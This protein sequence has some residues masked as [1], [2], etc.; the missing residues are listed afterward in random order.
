MSTQLDIDQ[1]P[2][3]IDE[4]TI[5]IEGKDKGTLVNPSYETG[6]LG[7][8]LYYAFL[9]KYKNE[10]SHITTAETYF[11][12]AMEAL[13]IARFQRVY[14]TDSID[15]HLSHI[16]RFIAFVNEHNLLN[17]D[18]DQYLA[19]LDGILFDLMKSK[20][21]I[22]DFDSLSGAMASGYYFLSRKRNGINVDDELKF[23]ILNLENFAQKDKDGDYFWKSPSL[24]QRMYIGISHGSSLMISFLCQAHTFGIE[25]ETCERIIRKAANFVQKQYRKSPYK[26]LFPNMIGDPIEPMQFALCYGDIGTGYALFEAAKVIKD[27]HLSALAEVVLSD[28]LTRTKEDNLT[29]DAGIFYGASGIVIAFD[30]LARISADERFEKRKVYWYQKIQEYKGESNEF[31]GFVSRL[32][33]E[34]HLWNVAFGWGILGV[35]I[36]LMSYSDKKFPPIDKLTFIA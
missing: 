33:K 15:G 24:Y 27:D 26:G 14:D 31:A 18:G 21:S 3:V 16:G 17:I 29:L 34:S 11:D 30:K 36:T 10:P 35:G 13:D 28:C 9:A 4:I 22:Q 19:S 7:Y 5:A 1:I 8:A 2:R 20:I 23:L 6:L 32:D 25:T 12:R